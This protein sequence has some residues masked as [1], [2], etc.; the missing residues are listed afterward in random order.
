MV[1]DLTR[2]MGCQA[3][4]VACK[5]ENNTPQE[6]Y[7][8]Y[9]FKKEVGKYPN[10]NY[11]FMPRPCMHCR[12]APCV[13]VCPTKAR[14]KRKD[15]VVLTNYN[16]C[17]GCKYC[18]AA[19]PY[20]VNYFNWEEPANKYYFQWKAGEGD[21]IYGSGKIT[22]YT[23]GAI[24][25]YKNPD[26]EKLYGGKIVS[27]G[28]HFKGIVEKCTFCVHRLPKRL[29][30]ACVSNCPVSALIFGDLDDPKSKVSQFIATR[31]ALQIKSELG[32][33]PQVYYVLQRETK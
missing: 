29:E 31:R 10:V 33:D 28:G 22:T 7:W 26:H 1:I 8:M 3:C 4:R 20:G 24:P 27:G 12:N 15:G 19:C 18:I 32:T 13:E 2:C 11:I 21:G 14:H 23:G 17:I 6:I 30:P 25:P 9:V 16:I 5:V